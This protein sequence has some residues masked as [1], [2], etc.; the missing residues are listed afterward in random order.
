MSWS[1][2]K[3]GF[4]MIPKKILLKWSLLLCFF[5]KSCDDYFPDTDWC[6]KWKHNYWFHA[7]KKQILLTKVY[8]N[9]RGTDK[10]NGICNYI[11]KSNS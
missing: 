6:R 3:I 8:S 4:K 9:L 2:R 1:I 10:F 5:Y 11:P 7:G